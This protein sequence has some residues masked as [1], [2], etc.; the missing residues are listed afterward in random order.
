MDRSSLLP[1]T[2]N[3]PGLVDLQVNGFAGFDFTGPAE[4][5]T[6]EEIEKVRQGLSRRGI[7]AALPTFI[8]DDLQ[9]LLA[10]ARKYRQLIER[11]PTLAVAFPKIHIEGPFISP[12][13]GP[14]GAHPKAFCVAPKEHPDFLAQIRDASGDRLG[15][16]TLAPELPGAL[17]LIARAS[18]AGI[19]VAI[20]HSAASSETIRAAVEAGARMSTHLGNGS[21]QMLPRLDNYVQAQLAD[22]RLAASF[23]PDGHHMPFFTLKNFLRAKTPRRSILVS[24]SIAAAGCGPGRYLLGGE[25]VVVSDDLRCSK[26]GQPNLAGSALTL[27]Q[28]VVNVC[29]HCDV[30]FEQ[31]WVMAS[32][33]PA[34]LIGLTPPPSVNVDVRAD[35]FMSL[36]PS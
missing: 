32:T 36:N 27:D 25:E 20:G 31:A 7:V 21:H 12:E 6:A 30:S 34:S 3:G 8:T 35:G 29:L 19:C 26:P 28:A 5:W 33:I 13:D 15:I 17:D 18:E 23:I 2:W 10:R 14:R 22:D 4:Q 11:N 9:S 16:L 24:D 1:K